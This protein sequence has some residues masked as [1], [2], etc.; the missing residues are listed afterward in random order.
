[1][2][3]S[4]LIYEYWK[5]LA[6]VQWP[7]WLQPQNKLGS[8]PAFLRLFLAFWTLHWQKS[9]FPHTGWQSFHGLAFI[10]FLKYYY[11]SHGCLSV[12]PFTLDYLCVSQ[13]DVGQP[14]S[15]LLKWSQRFIKVFFEFTYIHFF[16]NKNNSWFEKCDFKRYEV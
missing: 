9:D 6:G 8:N 12:Y 10:C 11:C 14:F 5:W 3:N 13:S 7:K 16:Q 4:T 15:F 1:M 2:Y